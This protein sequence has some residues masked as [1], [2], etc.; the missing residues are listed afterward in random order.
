M[1]QLPKISTDRRTLHRYVVTM[2]ATLREGASCHFKVSVIDISCY[3]CRLD[4]GYRAKPGQVVAL[5]FSG[6]APVRATIIWS[7]CDQAGLSFTNAFHYSVLHHL[8][9]MSPKPQSPPV[10]GLQ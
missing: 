8:I 6:F 4:L 1:R 9:A 7:T 3:G 5:H 2:P 10:H